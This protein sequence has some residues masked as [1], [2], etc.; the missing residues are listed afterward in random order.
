M[1]N[2]IEIERFIPDNITGTS[3][4]KLYHTY[5]VNFIQSM[6]IVAVG[7]PLDDNLDWDEFIHLRELLRFI[8]DNLIFSFT[9]TSIY[10]CI[11]Y[12]AIMITSFFF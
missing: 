5:F 3:L 2:L 11:N 1:F 10:Y 9:G 12:I 7:T 6:K 8:W 4:I